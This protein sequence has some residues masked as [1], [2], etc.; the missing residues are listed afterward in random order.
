MKFYRQKGQQQRNAKHP[1]KPKSARH[2]GGSV[3]SNFHLSSIEQKSKLFLSNFTKK[4][5]TVL[6]S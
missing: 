5:P 4:G 6:F 3:M 1:G 2:W